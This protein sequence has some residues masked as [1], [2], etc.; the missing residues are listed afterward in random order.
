M[1][2]HRISKRIRA[3]IYAWSFV[4]ACMMLL[5]VS[6]AWFTMVERVA[7]SNATNVMQPYYLTLLNPS[8]TSALQL[9][10]GSLMP[11]KVKQILFCVSNKSNEENELINM[12]GADFD[13]SLEL[14]HTDN[15]ALNYSLYALEATTEE[16]ANEFTLIAE[17]MVMVEG[18]TITK[19][20]YWN[21]GKEYTGEGNDVSATRHGEIDISGDEINSGTYISYASTDFHLKDDA[22]SGYDSQYFLMEIAWKEEA[23]S[24]FEK[25]DKE[26][27]MIY[28]LVKALL[29]K[30]ETQKD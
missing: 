12:G 17:D 1:R 18:E 11:G 26:T 15:L 24:N 14:I 28:L 23:T 2:K 27:D 29:P 22:Q 3:S 9:S 13:Y 8:E 25:Y 10:V 21:K 20:T 19:Y 6:F 30:P 16:E 4:V 5:G 7:E